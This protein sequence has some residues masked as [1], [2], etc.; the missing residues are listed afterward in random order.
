[1][2]LTKEQKKIRQ[3]VNKMNLATQKFKEK[4]AP[5]KLG[6][7]TK[8]GDIDDV[9]AFLYGKMLQNLTQNMVRATNQEKALERNF[10]DKQFNNIQKERIKQINTMFEDIALTTRKQLEKHLNNNILCNRISQIKGITT[11]RVALLM[12]EIKDI[13]RFEKPSAFAVYAGIAPYKNKKISKNTIREI[14]E[15]KQNPEWGFNTNLSQQFYIIVEQ[16]IKSKGFFYDYYSKVKKMILARVARNQESFEFTEEMKLE[17][18]KNKENHKMIVGK[19]YM[20]NKKNQSVEMFCHSSAFWKTASLF[21][22][23]LYE[24]WW[25]IKC[26]EN[27]TLRK[28]TE[29]YIF[30][31]P[32]SNG[33]VHSKKFTYDEIIEF[34]KRKVD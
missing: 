17:M 19:H 13:T 32:D 26:E 28:V 30:Q 3:Q 11:Y 23:I 34:E 4:Y 29:P 5:N 15:D 10:P 14:R 33:R 20:K 25:K 2:K 27:P 8:L 7:E 21:G 16:F 31:Y 6:V 22:N 1:M 9:E 12:A 18:A 24:E